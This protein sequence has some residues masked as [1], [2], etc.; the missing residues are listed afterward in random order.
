[1]H[2]PLTHLSREAIEAIL[3]NG[4][5]STTYFDLPPAAIAN[6]VYSASFGDIPTTFDYITESLTNQIR[7]G[8]Q[9]FT[10]KGQVWHTELYMSVDWPWLAYPVALLTAVRTSF[11]RTNLVLEAN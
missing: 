1:M 4:A 2:Q 6:L 11:I 3:Q 5:V 8:P 10:T 7:S 9:M